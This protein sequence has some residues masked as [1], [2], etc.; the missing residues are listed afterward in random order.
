MEAKPTTSTWHKAHNHSADNTVAIHN[1]I[2]AFPIDRIAGGVE[3]PASLPVKNA[4]KPL[5]PTAIR[6][7]TSLPIF[8]EE[9]LSEFRKLLLAS[10]KKFG[11]RNLL[12]FAIGTNCGSRAGDILTLRIHDVW[13][14]NTNNVKNSIV[15]TEEKTQKPQEIILPDPVKAAMEEYILSLPS[16]EGTLP[17]F[18]SQ[19]KQP[20][21]AKLVYKIIYD[22]DGNMIEKESF[23]RERSKDDTGCLSTK[24]FW[25][26]MKDIGN[27]LGLEH[28]GTHT[29]RKTFGRTF[30]KAYEGELVGGEMDRVDFLQ[31]IFNH[32]TGAYTLRYIE[33]TQDMKRE[34][35]K[36]VVNWDKN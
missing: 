7:K 24:S 26:I 32:S 31:K 2:Y 5:T 17:L 13:N 19:K 12:I 35:A 10:S 11:L 1:N 34:V 29:M 16:L 33:A 18:P 28:V 22:E 4:P 25:Q 15:F 9:T 27:V 20:H 8:D 6:P 30:Y 3:P 21:V 36:K 23:R 14:Y